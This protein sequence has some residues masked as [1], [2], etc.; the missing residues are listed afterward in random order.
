MARRKAPKRKR[1]DAEKAADRIRK[2]EQRQREQHRRDLVA[3]VFPDGEGAPAK[4]KQQLQNE[5]LLE[6]REEILLLASKGKSPEDIAIELNI[7]I[8]QAQRLLAQAYEQ[9]VAYFAHA[10]PRENFCRYAAF[11]LSLVRKLDD[12]IGDFAD[13]KENRQYNAATN[14]IKAQAELYDKLIA[15]GA[16]LGIIQQRK[17]QPET[18]MK[19]ADLLQALKDERLQMDSLIAELEITVER[20]T[21]LKV[22]RAGRTQH[23]EPSKAQATVIDAACEP[24]EGSRV[25]RDAAA[26]DDTPGGGNGDQHVLPEAVADDLAAEI[27]KERRKTKAQGTR[28]RSRVPFSALSI[29]PDQQ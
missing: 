15:R 28:S 13:D 8:P 4:S 29:K 22:N 5:A 20:R 23:R 21:T 19:R 12:L 14:A 6:L 18:Q 3:M 25:H 27:V 16:E 2:R 10:T 24:A 1:T 17:A 26:S 11:N 7:Q 9:M